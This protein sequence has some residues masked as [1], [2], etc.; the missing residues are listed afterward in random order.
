MG[1]MSASIDSTPSVSD[2]SSTSEICF[3]VVA[4]CGVGADAGGIAVEVLGGGAV[5]GVAAAA[6][7]SAAADK[8]GADVSIGVGAAVDDATTS[9]L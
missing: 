5:D 4:A 2:I 3:S 1:E 7:A 9:V 8:T 6:E